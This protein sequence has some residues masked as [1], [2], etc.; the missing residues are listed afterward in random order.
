MGVDK[1]GS[2]MRL[3]FGRF[4]GLRLNQV[5]DGYLKWLD[6]LPNLREPLRSAV[7][8][9]LIHR[10][11]AGEDGGTDFAEIRTLLKEIK[12]MLADLHNDVAGGCRRKEYSDGL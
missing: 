11:Q 3:P 6:R 12:S 1:M 4:K 5:S 9:E 2:D 8:D 7:S 10:S